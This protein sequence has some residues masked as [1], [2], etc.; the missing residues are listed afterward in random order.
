MPAL[1]DVDGMLRPLGTAIAEYEYCL[2]FK[3]WKRNFFLLH[4]E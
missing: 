3:V 1:Y 2:R 4:L